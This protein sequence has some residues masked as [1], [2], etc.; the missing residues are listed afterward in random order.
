[1]RTSKFLIWIFVF[2]F[3]IWEAASF[4]LALTNRQK[5]LDVCEEA[6]PSSDNTTQ[7]SNTTLSV[8]NYSTTFLGMQMGN[9][10]GLANCAQAVQADV[11]GSA[12]M[13]FVGQ[14]F[15]VIFIFY[16]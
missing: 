2:F 6:N 3:T 8:G 12:I 9:T 14:L 11:I 5:S 7:G 1:M 16:L 13:L 4:I 15:M 10:Y